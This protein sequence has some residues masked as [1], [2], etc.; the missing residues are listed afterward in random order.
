MT[1]F[2]SQTRSLRRLTFYFALIAAACLVFADI[3]ITTRSPGHE[4]WL[5]AHGLVTP[6][7][8]DPRQWLDGVIYTLTFALQGVILA[9]ALGFL[10]AAFYH[11]AWVRVLAACLRSVHEVFWALIFIQLFGI[12]TLSGVL[13]ILLPF[14][15]TMAKVF[16]EQLEEV[17]PGPANS[18]KPAAGPSLSHFLYT[19]LPLAAH[20]MRSYTAYRMECAIRSSVVLGFIGLPTIGFHLETALRTGD[21]SAASALL[22]T[23]LAMVWSLRF[24]FRARWL[25]LLVPAAFIARPLTGQWYGPNLRQFLYDCIPAPLRQDWPLEKTGRWL[26]WLGEQV[27]T[28]VW[29]TILIAQIVLVLTGAL[30]LLAS[31][32][33]SSHFVS[34]WPRRLGDSLL[35]VIRSLPEYLLNFLFLLVLGPSMLPAITAMTLHNGAI[36]AHLLGKH[37]DEL[38]PAVMESGPVSRFA[39]YYVPTLYQRF[40]AY[41]FYRWEIIIRE[42]AMLGILGI[43]TLG[44]YIDSAFEFLRFDVA[45]LLIAVSAALTLAADHLSRRLRR[46]FLLQ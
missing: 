9:A 35:L 17:D 11:R 5:M 41:C 22:Y 24:W 16:G 30:A 39:Y 14:S 29:N 33:N 2:L 28:G 7:I 46:Q 44:F 37:S 42:T 12:S 8:P 10:F 34:G 19:R 13:A 38:A 1:G 45:L 21:Y 18:V 20:A 25:W 3:D 23:L 15:G 43:P 27:A 4:L 6:R 40:L 31:T 36:I 32:L 26:A